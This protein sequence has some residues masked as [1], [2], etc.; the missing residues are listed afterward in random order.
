MCRPKKLTTRLTNIIARLG[1]GTAYTFR[2]TA[3]SGSIVEIRRR[4]LTNGTAVETARQIDSPASGMDLNTQYEMIAE[5]S[6]SRLMHALDVMADG[7]ALYDA[8]DRIVLYN[9]KYVDYSPLAADIIM[10]GVAKE[11]ILRKSTDA[12]CLCAQ[13]HAHRRIYPV[14]AGAA[15]QPA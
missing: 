2:Y 4:R 3:P 13:R 11:E 1:P 14:A 10:P 7:F 15:P 9:R 6:R 12:W 5:Q 8:N